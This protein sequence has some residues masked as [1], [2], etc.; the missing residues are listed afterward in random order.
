M[1][2]Q[3]WQMGIGVIR[4]IGTHVQVDGWIAEAKDRDRPLWAMLSPEEA[5][6]KAARLIEAAEAAEETRAAAEAARIKASR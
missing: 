1:A 5:R 3:E 6:I 2:K 4:T